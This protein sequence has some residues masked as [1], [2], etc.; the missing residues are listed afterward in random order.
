MLLQARLSRGG[1]NPEPALTH[2]L[3]EL[4]AINGA[5][6]G[7]CDLDAKPLPTTR[8]RLFFFVGVRGVDGQALAQEA[9]E[10]GKT[11]Q[12]CPQHHIS[13]FLCP[14]QAA[15][16]W[17]LE[18]WSGVSAAVRVKEY[19]AAFA[20][21]WHKAVQKKRLPADITPGPDSER[22]SMTHEAL[23]GQTPWLQAQAD[24]YYLIG[25]V[26]LQKQTEQAFLF[27]V[28]V[29]ARV[30]ERNFCSDSTR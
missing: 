8:P 2:V 5:S 26:L 20:V 18:D 13:S 10:L 15:Q 19:H 24:L 25:K 6:V 30:S 22:P 7:Y 3:G 11:L 1:G 23:K 28:C 9:A 14:P 4:E 16:A 21:G 17:K 12:A 27:G 29:G